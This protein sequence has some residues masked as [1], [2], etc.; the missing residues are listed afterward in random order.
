MGAFVDRWAERYGDDAFASY[1]I[2]VSPDGSFVTVCY[3]C[4]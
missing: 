3:V 4:P 2:D 1:S